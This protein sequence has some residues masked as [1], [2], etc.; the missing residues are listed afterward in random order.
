MG[1]H[2]FKHLHTI[3]KHRFKVFIY[4][5]KCGIFWRGLVH[6]LSKY[7]P[8]EFF[9]G[10]KY[11][12]GNRSPIGAQRRNEGYSKAWLH[13]KGRNRHHYEYWMDFS[14]VTSKYEPVK[15]PRVFLIEAF[16]DRISAS[17]VYMKKNYTDA[18]P[19]EYYLE[20]EKNATIN[21]ETRLEL[22]ALLNMLKDKGEK[23][24]FKYIRKNRKKPNFPFE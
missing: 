7:S 10:V 20:K 5:T 6:D 11:Y 12:Q 15:M 13:H 8:T 16:C 1:L 3:N 2:F 9:A 4:C 23:Y 18:S 19:L 14:P 21:K 17:K 24:T 22:E